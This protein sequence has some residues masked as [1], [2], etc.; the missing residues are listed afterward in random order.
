MREHMGYII[1]NAVLPHTQRVSLPSRRYYFLYI[2]KI[3]SSV[4]A[5]FS[6]VA[7]LGEG[8]GGVDQTRISV[9]FNYI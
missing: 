9:R 5:D 6:V 2:C 8:G 3:Q 1:H 7:D 4:H